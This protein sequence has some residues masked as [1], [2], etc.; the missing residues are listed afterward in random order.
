MSEFH[1][2]KLKDAGL[3]EM[4]KEELQGIV[5]FLV[6]QKDT[7]NL[8]ELLD[9]A[10]RAILLMAGLIWFSHF[11]FPE[12]TYL[13]VIGLGIMAVYYFYSYFA[14]KR[15]LFSIIKEKPGK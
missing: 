2:E 6:A 8:C 5:A 14:R 1:Y 4:T 7:A 15:K 13:F 11:G 9:S 12:Y 3:E 10:A